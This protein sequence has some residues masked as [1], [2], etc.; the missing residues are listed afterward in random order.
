MVG[1]ERVIRSFIS[2][3]VEDGKLLD[4]FQTL[5]RRLVE[6]GNVFKLVERANMHITLRFLGNIPESLVKRVMKGLEELKFKQFRMEFKGLGVFPSRSYVRVVWVGVGEG[7][8]ELRDIHVQLNGILGRLG[9]KSEKFSPHLTLARV[10]AVRNRAELVRL[11]QEYDGV[12]FGSMDV[13][14]VRLKRSTLTPRGP[15]YDTIMEVKPRP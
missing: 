5:Q 8:D 4:V 10:K 7:V 6:T 9:F 2:V 1:L 11:L 12:S 15:V 14:S 3:D 13:S